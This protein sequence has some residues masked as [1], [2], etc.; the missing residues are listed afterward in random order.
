M[1]YT[2]CSSL[3]GNDKRIACVMIGWDATSVP[4][5]SCMQMIQP[6]TLRR[7]TYPGKTRE[8]LVVAM[9]PRVNRILI[10]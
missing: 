2:R 6:R 9:Y 7:H 5:F 8:Q 1:R 3:Q 10:V 4:A